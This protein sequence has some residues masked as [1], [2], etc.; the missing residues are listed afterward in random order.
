MND[1]ARN[2]PRILLIVPKSLLLLGKT[3]TARDVLRVVLTEESVE[4]VSDFI[5]QPEERPDLRLSCLSGP[6]SSTDNLQPPP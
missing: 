3:L 2:V 6:T 4:N 1:Y 5:A